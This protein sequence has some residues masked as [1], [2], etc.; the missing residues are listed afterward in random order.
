MVST[1]GDVENTESY[2]KYDSVFSTSPII[3]YMIKPWVLA[4]LFRLA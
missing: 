4:C 3:T 2:L 1:M